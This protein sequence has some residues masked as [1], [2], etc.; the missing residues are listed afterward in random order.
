MSGG[1]GGRGPAL[2]GAGPIIRVS[3]RGDPAA[4]GAVLDAC[5]STGTTGLLVHSDLDAIE[6]ARAATARGIRVPED[7]ALVSYDDEEAHRGDPPLTAVRPVK[8]QIGRMAV[9]MMVARLTEGARRPANRLL[10]V[11]ELIVRG[12]SVAR[13]H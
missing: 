1:A 7:L 10:L 12:S 3:L 4:A 5:R 9:E 2:V 6:L 13:S 11:P 8:G